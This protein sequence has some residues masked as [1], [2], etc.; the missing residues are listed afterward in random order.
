MSIV[1]TEKAAA[2]VKEIIHEGQDSR[3][4]AD[5]EDVSASARGRRRL[6]R[7]PAQAGPRPRGEGA[8]RTRSSS[9]TACPW[10]ST[11]RA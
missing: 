6:Q 5:G 4:A 8:G 3:L 7:L 11:S 1:L 10:S 9:S 2:K